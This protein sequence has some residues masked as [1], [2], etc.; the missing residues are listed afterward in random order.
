MV[1]HLYVLSVQ[2]NS[3]K[4]QSK[5]ITKLTTISQRAP[6]FLGKF[7]EIAA[8]KKRNYILDHVGGLGQNSCSCS[9]AEL[10]A[11]LPQTNVSAP[12]QKRKMCLFAGFQRKAVV[13]CPSEED[14]KQRVQQKVESDGK[15]VPEHAILKMKGERHSLKLLARS[16]PFPSPS[17]PPVVTPGFY[18]LPEE[19][20]SF[21][22]VI[23][24]ELQKEEASK[25]LE[26]YREESKTAL[27]AEKK[28]NQG[29][30]MP[31]RGSGQR[32]GGR[33]GK[34]QFGRG[35]G[36]GHRGGARGGFQNRGN[37]RG[38]V[39]ASGWVPPSE[40]TERKKV[41]G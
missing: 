3:L 28:P 11:C 6:L 2:I 36:P 19:G 33:G 12:G 26:Q 22:E 29:S 1:L 27:P 14:Y 9:S 37:Y 15:E 7:I 32:G 4:R 21:S 13:V 35:A 31:K 34:N 24:A 40:E 38:G 16:L 41:T 17:T 39:L 8:R 18:A 30:A 25:L 23:F 20:D 10:R 5:D